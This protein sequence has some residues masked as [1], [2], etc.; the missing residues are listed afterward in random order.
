MI[1]AHKLFLD[2]I[3]SR[4][5]FK[6]ITTSQSKSQSKS[7]E[8]N[9]SNMKEEMPKSAEKPETKECIDN[10]PLQIA[11]LPGQTYKCNQCE[12]KNV[13]YPVI[14]IHMIK[15]HYSDKLSSMKGSKQ[16]DCL[17]CRQHFKW[18]DELACKYCYIFNN[19]D[20]CFFNFLK[21][22]PNRSSFF[23]LSNQ[24]EQNRTYIFY[25]PPREFDPRSLGAIRIGS[26]CSIR[27]FTV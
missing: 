24:T 14:V 10:K 4:K 26:K 8:G 5:S 19:N 1:R 16:W 21:V 3:P 15:T 20:N 18:E 12:L 22:G 27:T 23:L 7:T 17:L 11:L 13:S 6:I 2:E 9:I 25:L